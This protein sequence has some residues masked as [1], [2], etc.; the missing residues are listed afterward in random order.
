MGAVNKGAYHTNMRTEF[1]PEHLNG[2]GGRGALRYDT[3]PDNPS[4]EE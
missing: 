1:D 3:I 4:F 2:E